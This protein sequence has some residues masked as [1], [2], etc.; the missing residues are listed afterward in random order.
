MV[1]DTTAEWRQSSG[2]SASDSP[3]PT[4]QLPLIEGLDADEASLA[5]ESRDWMT[6]LQPCGHSFPHKALSAVEEQLDVLKELIERHAPPP[7]RSNAN[8]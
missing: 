6:A 3:T 8:Y 5:G 1:P 2:A 7:A 4:K